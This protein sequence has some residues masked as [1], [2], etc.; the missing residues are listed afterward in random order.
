MSFDVN[1]AITELVKIWLGV[2]GIAVLVL[3]P[4][5]KAEIP[6]LGVSWRHVA[7]S[8]L[9]LMS[10]A[11]YSRYGFETLGQRVDSS[12][13]MHHYVNVK[14][15]EELGYQ[16]LYPA[17]LLADLESEGP[18]YD[19]GQHYLAQN[20]GG[21]LWEP[22]AHGYARGRHVK[23]TRFTPERW[24]A[25]RHD[26]VY[27]QRQTGKD[28]GQPLWRQMIQGRGLA[29]SPTWIAVVR[30]IT[31]VMPVERVKLLGYLDVL[32]LGGAVSAVAW[33]YGGTG[34]LWVSLFLLISYS[35]RWPVYTWGLLRYDYV[36]ALILV[37][38]LLKKGRYGLAGVPFGW[39]AITQYFPVL[40]IWGML[41]K[42]LFGWR[43]SQAVGRLWTFGAVFALSV[44][45]MQ[46]GS[47][48]L[49]G[50]D[51]LRSHVQHRIEDVQ[52]E[53]ISNRPVGLAVGLAHRGQLRPMSVGAEQRRRMAAQSSTTALIGFGGLLLLGGVLR[54]ASDDEA[55]AM[56]VLL[57]F[58]FSAAS[59]YL[60][61]V[62]VT[63]IVIHGGNLHRLR[64]RVGL[65]ALLLLE[66]F[67]NAAETQL[68]G[69]R[70]F[71]VGYLSWGLV[72][73]GA[74]MVPWLW[75]DAAEGE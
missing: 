59:Y 24:R 40:W 58:L 31:Q 61:I 71:L 34:A 72:L 22:V 63:L 51:T 50:S 27:L 17:V 11:N 52:I 6:R 69:F 62:R 33:A 65:A 45:A 36:A 25:F 38:A 42:A 8:G 53:Q 14:Y 75:F 43:K 41:S 28:M 19:P 9:V 54:R 15:F 21:H 1:R 67:S 57:F 18:Y 10:A 16:D 48:L 2:G 70:M 12:D 37:T 66:V 35:A 47:T 60:Y 44:G 68:P 29:A 49:L 32:V 20:E 4:R 3:W 39:A 64:H 13:L 73:Y 74:V 30:P 23:N 26:V 46:F 5:L 7:L 56:G 55:F